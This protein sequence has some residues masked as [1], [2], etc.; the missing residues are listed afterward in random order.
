MIRIGLYND[1]VP[2]ALAQQIIGTSARYATDLAMDA[3]PPDHLLYLISQIYLQ[4]EIHAY[5][6]AI[7]QP[8]GGN[9]EVLV[10]FDEDEHPGLLIG[11]LLYMP[12]T[13][14]QEHCGVNYGAVHEGFRGRGVYSALIHHMLR[15][16]P[17]ATLTCFVESVPLYERMGFKVETARNSQVQMSSTPAPADMVM[18]VMDMSRLKDHPVV[19]Q[20]RKDAIATH[21]LEA[22]DRAYKESDERIKALCRKAETYVAKRLGSHTPT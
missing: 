1:A 14:S 10:A 18:P 21:G 3:C 17:S 5:L 12:L 13:G 20:A 22:V 11:F 16:Y 4:F 8:G 6:S 9:G 7:G 19:I 2:E 15:R